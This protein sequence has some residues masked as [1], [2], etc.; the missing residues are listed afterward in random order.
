M[1][2]RAEGRWRKKSSGSSFRRL[3][4]RDKARATVSSKRDLLIVRPTRKTHF[5]GPAW[6]SL[7]RGLVPEAA[8]GQQWLLCLGNIAGGEEF[9]GPRASGSRPPTQPQCPG[10]AHLGRIKGDGWLMGEITGFIREIYRSLWWY[11]YVYSRPRG[12]EEAPIN[13]YEA[14]SH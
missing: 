11:K 14:T 7:F 10:P 9:T 1:R 13:H 12:N 5:K 3:L 6:S 2:V 4:L 8:P